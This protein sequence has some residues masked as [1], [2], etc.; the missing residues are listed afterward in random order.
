M[1]A[2]SNY[3]IPVKIRLEPGRYRHGYVKRLPATDDEK[4]RV[5]HA[6][7]RITSRLGGSI[8]HEPGGFEPRKS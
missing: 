6:S 5:L 2:R 1:M 7:G 4:V 3:I 8:I